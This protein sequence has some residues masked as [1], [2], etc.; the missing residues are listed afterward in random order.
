M[1]VPNAG[2][3]STGDAQP[4]YIAVV[5]TSVRRP[6][7]DGY[8]EA[9]G[10]MDE[11]ARRQPGY[12]GHDSARDPG[13]GGLGI[14]VSYWASEAAADGW[15]REAEHAAIQRRGRDSWYEWY[16]VRVATVTR[17]HGW[18]SGAARG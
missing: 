5:F 6:G 18:P 12:L 2:P 13:P 17:Q 7:D 4:P 16:S 9:A 15:R 3:G 8:D 14:T 1:T 11:L 10:R